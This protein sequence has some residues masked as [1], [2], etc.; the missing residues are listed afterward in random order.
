M[1]KPF[2]K[3][4][5][6]K[7]K[8]LPFIAPHLGSTGT[9][10]EPFMGSG[11]LMLNRAQERYVGGDLNNDLVNLFTFIKTDTEAFLNEAEEFFCE[12]TRSEQA[13]YELREVF[14]TTVDERK[15]A[16]LFLYL[17]KH[18]FNGLCR[19]NSKTGRFNVPWNHGNGA[20]FPRQELLQFADIAQ[21]SEFYCRP[22]QE[23]AVLA[24]KGD[25]VYMDPPY[26]PIQGNEKTFTEYAKGEFGLDKQHEVAALGEQLSARGVTVVV[27][28]HATDLSREIYKNAEIIPLDV[29][30]SMGRYKDSVSTAKELLAVY[31]A[32]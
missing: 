7:F 20:T 18:C 2:L 17:N 11:S 30:R 32:K 14:N 8:V 13:Y 1:N 5:G 28:N 25:V 4:A 27:S 22:F 9:L 15:K 6:N 16:C 24:S 12:E 31:R 23:T 19:Y 26:L 29:K 3:W 21:T 10:Y